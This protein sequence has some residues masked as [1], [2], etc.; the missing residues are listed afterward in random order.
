LNKLYEANSYIEKNVQ[1]AE[2]LK[3][4]RERERKREGG[5]RPREIERERETKQAP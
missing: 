3:G 1:F 2:K 4:E 5:K